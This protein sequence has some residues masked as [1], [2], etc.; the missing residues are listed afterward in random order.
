MK[1]IHVIQTDKPSS[2]WIDKDTNKLVYGLFSIDNIHNCKNQHIY[3]TNSEE[4]KEGDWGLSKLN[5][6]ILFGR[7]YNEKFYKKI[8]L[9]TDQDLI[10][11]GVQAID[12]DFLKWFVAKANDS[13]KPIDIVEVKTVNNKWH[14]EDGSVLSV[15]VYDL[16]IQK[17][18][19]FIEYTNT[20]DCTSMIYNSKEEPDYTALLQPVGTKQ[21]LEKYS[22]RFDNDKSAIGNPETW[23]KRM[24][25]EPKQETIK[26][27]CVQCCGTG[28]IQK[29]TN[30]KQSNFECDLCNG[31]G[32]WN[33]V[34][35]PKQENENYLDS[36]GVTKSELKTFRE[37]VKQETLEEAQKQQS[38]YDN[39]HDAKEISSRIKVVETLEEVAERIGDTF[40]Y[41]PKFKAGVIYGVIEG[42]KW[43][44]KKDIKELKPNPLLMDEVAHWDFSRQRSYSE[45]EVKD[46]VEQTIEKF[47][48]HTYAD[49]TK[50]EM[51]KLWFEQFKKK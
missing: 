51:K 8:I 7:S 49:K 37:V 28:E 14:N 2:I 23:G 22:E 25:E 40:D 24:V 41:E 48:K 33:K 30:R 43:Q 3:I 36:F 38:K 46:I 35:E 1:N 9:T 31:K 19:P 42:A 20:N 39:L 11:D 4:I 5:E 13:G 27:A 6:V 15:N 34:I 12:D 21:R 47:Y 18:E 45:E 17:E 29:S 26:I 44:Q 10:K 32:Y 50:A 16:I